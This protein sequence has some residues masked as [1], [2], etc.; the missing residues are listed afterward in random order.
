MGMSGSGRAP[1]KNV[2]RRVVNS[3]AYVPLSL[4]VT[5]CLLL[6]VGVN[7]LIRAGD[8]PPVFAQPRTSIVFS[9]ASSPSPSTDIH[10][11][12]LGAVRTPGLYPL[13]PATTAKD[14]IGIA[15]GALTTA[16]LSRVDLTATLADGSSVYVP[17]KGETIPA[18]I[19]GRIALNHASAQDLRNALDVSLTICKRVVAYRTAHGN[20]TAISQLLLVPVSQ[21]TFDRIKNLVAV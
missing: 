14:L 13:P 6:G 5:L 12:V 7:L 3:Q 19:N 18:E 4:M 1:A 9:A 2:L 16:D 21:T 11:I 17:R 8:W 20:F 10:V 15:G